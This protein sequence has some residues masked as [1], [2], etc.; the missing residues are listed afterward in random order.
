MKNIAPMEPIKATAIPKGTEWIHEIKFDGIRGILYYDKIN[1]KL[2][3]KKGNECL[4]SFP[5]IKGFKKI[6]K[7]NSAIIDGELTVWNEKSHSF[8]DVLIRSRSKSEKKI[9]QNISKYPLTYVMF[10]ILNYNDKDLLNFPLIERKNILK[11][12]ISINN[13]FFYSDYYDDGKLLFDKVKEYG[14]E[15][16]VSKK[17]NSPYVPLKK[18]NYWYK[19]KVKKKILAVVSGVSIENNS[20]KSLLLGIFKDN[21]LIYIGNASLG[22][23]QNDLYTLKQNLELLKIDKNPFINLKDSKTNVFIK[24][25]LTCWIEFFE[26]TN[27]GKLR[28]PQIIGFSDINAQK[29]T[30]KEYSI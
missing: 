10:D 5:E 12:S 25:I 2:Y 23:S 30:G 9:K 26:W 27:S 1:F 29:A 17:K 15:G 4:A 20:I 28:H 21:G 11:D 22:L 18:H 7:G 16:I 14:F 13:N 8:H 6:F 3:S 24:P 19:I